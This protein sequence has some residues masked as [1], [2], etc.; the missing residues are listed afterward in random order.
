MNARAKIKQMTPSS[1]NEVPKPRN[2]GT[3]ACVLVLKAKPLVEQIQRELQK[4][5]Q[6]QKIRPKLCVVLV[7]NDPASLLYT[8]RKG[9]LASSL[10]I[11]HE[12]FHFD[13][14]T[15][16]EEVKQCIQKLNRN[17][18]VHGIL[19]QRPLPRSFLEEEVILWIDPSKDVDAF[20]P[21]HAGNLFLGHP[22]FQ[23]CTPAGI[24]ALLKH[25]Q[26][27]LL[28]KIA[29]VVGRSSIVGKPMASLLLQAHATVLQCHSQT[30]ELETMT[31]LAEVL[32]VASG[33]RHLI[34]AQHVK[35][36]AIIIDVG[37]HKTPQGIQG[38]VLYEEVA[39]K[40]SAITPVPG[41]VGPMTLAM[42][43][44]NTVMAAEQ[45]EI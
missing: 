36:G 34:Q 37:I 19:L 35:E 14:N 6:R 42:L 30:T 27:N 38:D 20:H 40:A 41:G 45:L 21:L 33:K 28:G 7:G 17:P 23:P 15:S 44:Q 18:K 31:Q 3:L 25:Y 13:A 29:C 2:D 10:G 43:M 24:M 16:P 39:L 1:Q 9:K 32:V 12:T 22:T 8:Q 4:R 11:A 5:I 26:I